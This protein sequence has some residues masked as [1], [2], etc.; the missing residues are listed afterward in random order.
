MD[1]IRAIWIGY[2]RVLRLYHFYWIFRICTLFKP[3]CRLK[4][5]KAVLPLIQQKVIKLL[6]LALLRFISVAFKHF[7]TYIYFLHQGWSRDFETGGARPIS[8]KKKW[9]GPGLVLP[10][11][12]QK[13]VGPGP[14]RPIPRLQPCTCTSI[15]KLTHLDLNT[16][17]V[18]ML[19]L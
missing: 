17:F 10:Y 3:N 18:H 19:N 15:T 6:L 2:L 8:S 5:N 13:V 9:W 1:K 11:F 14:N 16:K 12:R 4:S 7:I